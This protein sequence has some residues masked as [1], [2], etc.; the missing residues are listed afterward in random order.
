[1]RTKLNNL[2]RALLCAASA[3]LCV[4]SYAESRAA[5]ASEGKAIVLAEKNPD[6]A[7]L[8][9]ATTPSQSQ[10]S[11][12]PATVAI[13]RGSVFPERLHPSRQPSEQENQAI[14]KALTTF[15]A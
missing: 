6:W 15:V 7:Q 11:P 8:R 12:D 2:A 9:S 3:A 14:S 10:N 1:M 5:Q 13:S 4:E